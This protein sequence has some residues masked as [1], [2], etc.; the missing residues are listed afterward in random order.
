MK[1]KPV[2]LCGGAGTRLWINK[3]EAEAKQ[4]INFGNWTLFEKTLHR[5]KGPLYDAPIISTNLKYIKYIQKFL[6]KNK[7]KD[8]DIILEPSKKN[9]APA[10]LTSTLLKNI[11]DDKPLIFLSSDHLVENLTKFNTVLKKNIKNLTNNNIFIF[12]IKPKF[13]STQYGYLLTK[14]N[15][16]NLDK[17]IKFIEKPKQNIAKKIIKKGGFWNCGIFFARKESIIYNFRKYQKEIFFNCLESL[18]KAK[19]KNSLIYLNKN[20]FFKNSSKSFDYAILEKSNDINAIKLDIPWSDMGS[21]KE[22]CLMFNNK[23]N[24]YYKKENIFI[25]PWGKYINLYRGKN[26]LI[27]EIYVK[28]KGVLSLQKH[29]HR[30]EHWVITEGNPK[31]TLNKKIF[32]KKPYETIFIP[33]GSIHRIENQNKKPVRIIEAQLGKILKETDIVR[34]KDIYGR[35]N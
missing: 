11:P 23:K 21:W 33:K 24:E 2:I 20:R 14:K 13:P 27:K 7:F 28:P 22:I 31:I 17:V 9:T 1:I 26:F 4:F 18:K 3:N 5:I 10:I 16:K 19:F 8:Y 25:R 30:S 34:F 32:F 15:R 35:V 29:F 12:G 6:M